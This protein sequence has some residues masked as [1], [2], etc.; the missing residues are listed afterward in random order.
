MFELSQACYE[1]NKQTSEIKKYKT[2]P[3]IERASNSPS[4]K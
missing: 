1:K 4:T 3:F 2:S